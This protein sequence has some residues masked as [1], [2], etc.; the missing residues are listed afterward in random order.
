MWL[1]IFQSLRCLTLVSDAYLYVQCLKNTKYSMSVGWIE[2]TSE[3]HKQSLTLCL[4]NITEAQGIKYVKGTGSWPKYTVLADTSKCCVFTLFAF[5][6]NSCKDISGQETLLL[7]PGAEGKGRLWTVPSRFTVPFMPRQ[8]LLPCLRRL[9]PLL[10]LYID[11][12]S[13]SV[14][15]AMTSL[16]STVC[17][18]LLMESV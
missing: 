8:T 7:A 6:P 11:Y 15:S 16:S 12:T 17:Q 4:S 10:Y 3:S 5:L 2:W 13:I 9:S 14:T 1:L 18:F